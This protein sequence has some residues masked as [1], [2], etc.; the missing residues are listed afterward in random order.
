MRSC[1]G[2]KMLR[3]KSTSMSVLQLRR[4]DRDFLGIFQFSVFSQLGSALLAVT[5]ALFDTLLKE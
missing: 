2:I 5:L 3:N 4:D 1:C